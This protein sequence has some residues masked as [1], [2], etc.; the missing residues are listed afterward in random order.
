[1]LSSMY[2]TLPGEEFVE[3]ELKFT[4]HTVINNDHDFLPSDLQYRSNYLPL[5]DGV[6]SHTLKVINATRSGSNGLDHSCG[7]EE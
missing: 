6:I 5:R 1:M 3:S 2:V 4:C 7:V